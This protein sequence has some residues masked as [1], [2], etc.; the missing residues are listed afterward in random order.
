MLTT[1]RS[2]LLPALERSAAVADPRSAIP[3]LACCLIDNATIAATDL[4][5]SVTCGTDATG[6]LRACVNAKDLLARV[7]AMPDGEI[8]L[9]LKKDAL[10]VTGIGKRKF[11]L[12]TASA[13]DFPKLPQCDTA[14]AGTRFEAGELA[15][16]IQRVSY[17]I[18]TDETRAHV[19]SLCLA[20]DARRVVA[21]DGHRL[22]LFTTEESS[23]ANSVLVPLRA[24][25]DLV[26]LGAGAVN[27]AIAGPYLFAIA[28]GVTYT[29]KLVDAQFPPYSQVIPKQVAHTV[30][31]PRQAMRDAIAAVALA[32]SDR[33]GGV[34]FTLAPGLLTVS[35]ESPDGGDA[36]DEV[37][38]DH[39]G[40]TCRIGFAARYWL[41]ALDA[42][43]DD[44]VSVG[45]SAEL[46]PATLRGSGDGVAVVMPLRI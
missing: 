40:E 28:G 17:C 19:N 41:E 6:S 2:S 8:G 12:Q 34:V 26:R 11:T 42:L 7:K 15:A 16:L 20:G 13:D 44:E 30:N 35:A 21:T 5:R 14:M 37:P 18:S 45:F 38:C 29:T 22:A 24:I 3:I 9:A 46:D 4:Y 27:L 36:S 1:T 33:T 23:D 10:V 31:V 39:R 32:A 43:D 25:K